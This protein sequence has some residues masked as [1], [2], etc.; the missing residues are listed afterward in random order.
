MA[1]CTTQMFRPETLKASW[2][3][4]L[5]FPKLKSKSPTPLACS[6]LAEI[7]TPLD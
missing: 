2:L 6:V 7:Y 5:R 4:Q 3:S 1:F